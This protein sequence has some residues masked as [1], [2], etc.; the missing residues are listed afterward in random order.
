MRL[1]YSPRLNG[2]LPPTPG[3]VSNRSI[4]S[5]K[6]RIRW[7]ISALSRSMVSSRKS[8]CASCSGQ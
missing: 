1:D 7:A 4:A 2:V 6:G 8:M 3:I 5:P